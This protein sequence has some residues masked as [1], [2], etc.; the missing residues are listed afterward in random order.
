ML[1][2]TILTALAMAA[3]T[4]PVAAD[5]IEAEEA[6][7]IEAFAQALGGEDDALAPHLA[8]GAVYMPSTGGRYE[9]AESIARSL[10]DFPDVAEFSA[11][12]DDRVPLGEGHTLF[13]GT[14][15]VTL[16]PEMGGATLPGE[17]VLV[18]EHTPEG[19]KLLRHV[20]FPARGLER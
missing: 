2:T 18:A 1:R 15:S 3:F 20:A 6:K 12:I 17:Y 14:Y 4:F 5:P 9:G 13:V 8:D 16:P 10:A 7:M 11:G 19:M